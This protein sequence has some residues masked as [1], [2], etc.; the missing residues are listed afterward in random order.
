MSLEELKTSVIEDGKVDADEVEQIRTAIYAED[1]DE[2]AAVSRAEA[3]MLFDI[4]DAVTGNADNDPG[5][6]PLFIEGVTKHVLE[7]ETSPGVIDDDESTYLIDR[8]GKDGQC[9][10]TE[11]ALLINITSKATSIPD[12]LNNYTIENLKAAVSADGKIDADECKQIA[13]VIYGVGGFEGEGVSREE[14]E[15]MFALNDLVSGA[16]NAPEW[17]D[18]FVEAICKHVLEDETSPGAIDEAEAEWLVSKVQADDKYDD[19]E[20]ALFKALKEKATDVHEKLTFQFEL[21][22]V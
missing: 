14:A 12:A 20:I 8:I 7:D 10:S 22:G 18:L 6:T 16:D 4:N 3:D 13:A 15:L 17:T 1:G 19:V 11:L 2:G 21:M 9:D 5:W